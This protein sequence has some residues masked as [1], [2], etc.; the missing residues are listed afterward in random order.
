M[1]KAAAI[2]LII[3]LLLA[4]AAPAALAAATYSARTPLTGGS[5]KQENVR[6]AVQAIDGVTIPRGGRFSFNE[7]VG[8][9]SEKYG[10]RRAPNGRGATVTGGGVAQVATTLYIALLKMPSD[11]VLDPVST[12][13]SR[14][15]DTY[16]SDPDL[17]VVT[18]FDAGI[19]LSFTNRGEP[20]T[21][22]LWTND[23]E[24]WCVI[25]TGSGEFGL[26]QYD[27][28][29]GLGFLDSDDDDG[30]GI[31]Y[32][33]DGEDEIF[34]EDDGP[35]Y[36]D[37]DDGDDG[38]PGGGYGDMDDEDGG[39]GPGPYADGSVALNCG[40]E[41]DVIHNVTL[42]ADSVNDTTLRSGDTFSFND[43]VGPRTSKYGYRKA[44]NGRGVRVMGGGVAQVASALWLCVKNRG[45]I[46]ILEKSTYGSK[47][48]QSY[49]DSSSDAIVT[50][51]S[52]GRDFVFRYT[53]RSRLTFY[54]YVDDGWLYCDVLED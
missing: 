14:F 30:P 16:V 42:A 24:L 13:G 9:R 5:A 54:T 22:D 39:Y 41:R 7:I 19:D 33:D 45:D 23:S 38:Y 11:V 31:F 37:L 53:G 48:N 29:E 18:D 52:S 28:G 4:L 35:G 2:T 34:N 50:D 10:F 27:D 8:P 40:G 43:I 1:K 47:Y 25:T 6:R 3:A 36:G 46:T 26:I 49:V 21:I 51:Y 12:Y 20:M 44:T 17:A 15:S 32:E